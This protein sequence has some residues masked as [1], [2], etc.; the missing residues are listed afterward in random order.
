MGRLAQGGLFRSCSAPPSSPPRLR[1]QET[2]R[3][4]PPQPS[5]SHAAPIHPPS[6]PIVLQSPP[7]RTPPSPRPS[8]PMAVKPPA[9]HS[10][11]L[12]HHPP[13]FR[14]PRAPQLF[15]ASPAALPASAPTLCPLPPLPSPLWPF[16]PLAPQPS[17]APSLHLFVRDLQGSLHPY[18]LP[19]LVTGEQLLHLLSS[20]LSLSPQV[21]LSFGGRPIRPHLPLRELCLRN[22]STIE[23]LPRLSGG[24][25]SEPPSKRSRPISRSE[26]LVALRTF[27]EGPFVAW[28]QRVPPGDL[29]CDVAR[30]VARWSSTGADAFTALAVIA[31]A[32]GVSPEQ[33]LEVVWA[34]ELI[35]GWVYDPSSDS[36]SQP[37]AMDLDPTASGPL[38]EVA[39][40]CRELDR[41]TQEAAS[42]RA[43]ISPP[44]SESNLLQLLSAAPPTPWVHALGEALLQALRAEPPLYPSQPPTPT[45]TFV[46]S[47][48]C[49]LQQFALAPS[50]PI[51]QPRTPAPTFSGSASSPSQGVCFNC[52]LPGH[53]ARTCRQP[54]SSAASSTA[55]SFRQGSLSVL[56]SGQTIFT[57]APGRTF[58]VASSPP[59][60]CGRCQQFHWF[61]Q[62]CPAEGSSPQTF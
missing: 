27:L 21:Y 20:R 13:L 36:F 42:L 53:W 47:V 55:H 54:R 14:M 5:P 48:W 19:D 30:L 51:P 2:G 28:R 18:T 11:P 10:S 4:H 7:P 22:G 17:L 29:A 37:T 1:F 41:V 34:W 52:G 44:L 62:P 43:Q 25:P 33:S 60:P 32:L 6:T 35:C 49:V 23:V 15:P 39:R 3:P 58:D 8:Q 24:A 38:E 31:D 16:T 46:H 59:Y 9:R 26:A 61:F 45:S 50:S 40:L 57:A 56:P 12:A